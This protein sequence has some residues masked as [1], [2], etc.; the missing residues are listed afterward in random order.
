MFNKTGKKQ[1]TILMN[2]HKH[3]IRIKNFETSWK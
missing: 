1:S 2:K 3:K